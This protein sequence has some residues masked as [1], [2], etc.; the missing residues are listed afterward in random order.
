[1]KGFAFHFKL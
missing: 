1:M